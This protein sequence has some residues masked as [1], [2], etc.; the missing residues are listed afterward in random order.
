MEY[1]KKH[2]VQ[3]VQL[4]DDTV[5]AVLIDS[6]KPVSS[7][8]AMIGEKLGLKNSEEFSLRSSSNDCTHETINSMEFPLLMA[9]LACLVTL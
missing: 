6:S 9:L 4:M 8:I 3:K 1:K 7:I 2:R 5:K